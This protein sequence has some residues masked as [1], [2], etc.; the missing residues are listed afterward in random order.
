MGLFQKQDHSLAIVD[1]RTGDII[2]SPSSETLAQ[3]IEL[4]AELNSRFQVLERVGQVAAETLDGRQICLT[5]NVET[6]N[7]LEL[8]HRYGAQGIGL[9]RSENLFLQHN[10]FPSESEQFLVYKQLVEK[11]HGKPVVI[12]TFDV[13][14]DKIAKDM[15][16]GASFS[17][18]EEN[19]FLGCRALRF[20][21]KERHIFNDQLRAILRASAY[22]KVSVLFPMVTGLPELR[23]A[24]QVIAELKMQLRQSGVPFDEHMR[25]GCMIEVPSA[26]I[27]ADLLAQECDFLSVG[28]N[29]LVQYCLAVDRGNQAM[30]FLYNPAHPSILRLLQMA[31][32]EAR[33]FKVPLNVCGE[34]AADP[35]FIPLLLGLGVVELSVACREIPIVKHII[36][37][38]SVQ[39]AVLMTEKILG[40][41]TEHEIQQ[42]LT[43][44]CKKNF[45]DDFFFN[46]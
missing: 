29:D 27:I 13:G 26:A 17:P 2:L 30:S 44:V 43:S 6:L 28:T 18:V 9:Y 24:K 12:R 35:R 4:Q 42:F 39:D 38:T 8:L 22:G 37:R 16:S 41:A 31:I 7:E 15:K 21:L 33:R 14:G 23:D 3:Y 34:V 46:Y 36:R 5:A 40:M 45:P 32:K 20:L 19:P 1:G 11:M 10:R 25:V